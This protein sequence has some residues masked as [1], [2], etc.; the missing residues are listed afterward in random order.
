MIDLFQVE[1]GISTINYE[2][3]EILNLLHLA[4]EQIVD[5]RP[6]IVNDY[7][8]TLSRRVDTLLSFSISALKEQIKRTGE[9][10]G[11]IEKMRAAAKA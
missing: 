5:F 2:M 4:I 8:S 3:E 6:P 9:L 10:E 1:N 7:V 11:E